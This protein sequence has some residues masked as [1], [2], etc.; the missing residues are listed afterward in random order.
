MQKAQAKVRGIAWE[1][2]YWEWLQI[3]QDSGRLHERGVHG[4]QWVMARN[5]DRGPYSVE[6]VQIVRC[7]T[8]NAAAARGRVVERRLARGLPT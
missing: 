5:G 7:E 6:N 8:N 2:A 1:L 3:W 4:G